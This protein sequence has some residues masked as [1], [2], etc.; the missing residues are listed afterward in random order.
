MTNNDPHLVYSSLSG[1]HTL[2][3]L[4]FDVQIYRLD[5]YPVWALKIVSDKGLSLVWKKLF[6]TEYEALEAF[7]KVPEKDCMAYLLS[8]TELET[9]H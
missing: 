6:D 3:G 7:A 2:D 8:H 5:C 1:Q 4:D 9:M